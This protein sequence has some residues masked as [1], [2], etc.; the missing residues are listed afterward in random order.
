VLSRPTT[1]RRLSELLARA[2]DGDRAAYEAFLTEAAGLVRSFVRKRLPPSM[3][4]EDV[5]Q[6]VLFAVHRHRHSY[7]PARSVAPWLYAIARHRLLDAL[8][9]QRRVWRR[10]L[11]DE[12]GASGWPRLEELPAGNAPADPTG[13][14]LLRHALEQLTSA[15]REVIHLLKLE[16]YSVS[17]VAER[18]GRTPSSVKVT[19][20]RGYKL[21]RQLLEGS[22]RDH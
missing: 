9:R 14:G 5:V 18:T 22:S 17:E 10:E 16:G 4:A 21:L 15:Q 20:H 1:E 2:Q 8:K 3:D 6:D 12:P 11:Q 19:A 7:D 13:F